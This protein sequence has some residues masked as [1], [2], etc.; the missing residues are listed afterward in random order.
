MVQAEKGEFEVMQGSGRK[1]KA[2]KVH[3]NSRLQMV[4]HV[5]TATG[6]AGNR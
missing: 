2:V 1:Y 6:T 4:M 3:T 5:P